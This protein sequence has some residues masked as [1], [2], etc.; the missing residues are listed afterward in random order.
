[1][2]DCKKEQENR[3]FIERVDESSRAKRVHYIPH[4]GVEKNSTTTP[5][6]IVYDCSCRQSE[7][8]PSLND[9]L[10]STPP[11]LNDLT[12]LLLRFRLGRYAVSTDIEKA[13]LHVGL[14]EDDRDATRFLWL[15]DPTDHKSQLVT[16]RFRVVLFGATCSHL[17]SMLHY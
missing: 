6:R 2:G 15:S 7:R 1:M 13:F 9:C 3:G 17:F 4:H 5:I 12:T 8:S 16:Y 14:H 11:E 10:E